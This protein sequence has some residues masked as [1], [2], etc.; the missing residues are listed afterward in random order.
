MKALRAFLA[1]GAMV[2]LLA[3]TALSAASDDG[4]TV[5]SADELDDLNTMIDGPPIPVAPEVLAPGR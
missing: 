5:M 4:L 1:T 2:S 3:G